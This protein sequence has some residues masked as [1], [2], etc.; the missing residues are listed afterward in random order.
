MVTAGHRAAIGTHSPALGDGDPANSSSIP[1]NKVNDNYCDC[2]DGS[3]EP[4]S[5]A[6]SH[7]VILLMRQLDYMYDGSIPGSPRYSLAC[8]TCC[9]TYSHHIV[10]QCLVCCAQAAFFVCKDGISMPTAFVDD[11]ICDCC[12]GAD[13]AAAVSCPNHCKA[14]QHFQVTA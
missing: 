12:D 13:E 8:A 11:G 2:P 3:D 9:R 14:Y 1:C 10:T 4:G 7:L 6:C 5:A